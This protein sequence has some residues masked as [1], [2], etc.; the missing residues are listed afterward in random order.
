MNTLAVIF[1]IWVLKRGKLNS[2]L[3]GMSGCRLDAGV[4]Y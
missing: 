4:G 3:S 2:Q 1:V